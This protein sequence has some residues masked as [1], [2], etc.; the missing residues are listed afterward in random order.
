MDSSEVAGLGC[1]ASLCSINYHSRV[2]ERRS[3]PRQPW[4]RKQFSCVWRTN[5]RTDFPPH[6]DML[7]KRRN[8]ALELGLAK[9][10]NLIYI[11]YKPIFIFSVWELENA[12][13][14]Q[15][16][17]WIIDMLFETIKFDSTEEGLYFS[18]CHW[19]FWISKEYIFSVFYLDKSPETIFHADNIELTSLKC[20]IAFDDLIMYFFE[21]HNS[22]LLAY[23]SELSTVER[24]HS[25]SIYRIRKYPYVPRSF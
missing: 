3:H 23:I 2:H 18:G 6:L 5:N 25:E 20:R 22:E 10:E 21:I 7:Q 19:I 9:E 15:S 1:D 11:F 4:F 16:C 24:W 14:I 8:T 17:E 13:K 12:Q